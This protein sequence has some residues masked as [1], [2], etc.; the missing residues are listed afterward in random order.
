MNLPLIL[1]GAYS[2]AVV[3]LGLWSARLVR[4]SSDF[5]VAGRSLGPGLIFTSMIAA[6]IGAGATVGVTGLAY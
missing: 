3:A 5:F 6:N 1:V 4:G 2:V